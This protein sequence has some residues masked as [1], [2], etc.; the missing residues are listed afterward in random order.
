VLQLKNF[1][2]EHLKS[3]EYTF[4]IF[5]TSFETPFACLDEIT[6]ELIEKNLCHTKVLFDLLLSIGNTSERFVEASFDGQQFDRSS[7]N[8]VKVDK[9][10]NI[11]SNSR[12][13][14]YNHL[15]LLE[16]SVLNSSQKKLLSKG[17][18]I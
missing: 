13:Y 1:E 18:S 8:F 7:F 9:K 15:F 3:S 16:E 11:R 4:V 10:N 12:D 2:I 17:I 5:S 14:Y 6:A